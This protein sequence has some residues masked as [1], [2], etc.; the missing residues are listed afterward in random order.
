MGADLVID[1]QKNSPQIVG[2]GGHPADAM[3]DYVLGLA[4]GRKVLYVG[5]AGMENPYSALD[6]HEQL[7]A[8]VLRFAPWPPDDLRAFALEHDVI[9]V[10]GARLPRGARRRGTAR[11]SQSLTPAAGAELGGPR[12]RAQA[13]PDRR[14][15]HVEDEVGDDDERPPEH[16]VAE[17]YGPLLVLLHAAVLRSSTTRST[18]WAVSSIESSEM[19]ITGQLIRRCSF[20]ACSSSS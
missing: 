2:L 15:Q 12:D 11:D 10:G 16:P 4:R 1:S 19:S 14:Q 5:T 13:D 8:S 17:R 9:L 18:R 7:G 20:A 6:W 3:L